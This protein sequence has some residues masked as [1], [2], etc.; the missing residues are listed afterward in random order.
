VHVVRLDLAHTSHGHLFFHFSQVHS[1]PHDV[2]KPTSTVTWHD[3]G[4]RR[5]EHSK[6]SGCSNPD[7]L[8][9]PD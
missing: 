7:W 3:H 8:K 2:L 9:Y 6:I 5:S 4:I 1:L